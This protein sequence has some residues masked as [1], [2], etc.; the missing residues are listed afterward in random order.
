M[1][2]FKLFS[3]SMGMLLFFV[4]CSMEPYEGTEL[5][6]TNVK[7]AIDDEGCET[8]FAI[9]ASGISTCFLEDGFN[10]WGWTIGALSPSVNPRTYEIY[11][12]AGKCDISNPEVAGTVTLNYNGGS[13]TVI[14]TAALG[15]VFKETHVYIGT[16]EY[17]MQVKGNKTV[18]TV[19]PGQYPYKHDNLNNTD[20]D[21]YDEEEIGELPDG[22]IYFIAHAVVC[23]VATDTA[24][25]D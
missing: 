7:G 5:K 24:D 12:G 8:G 14:F 4:S 10:R 22:D 13:A 1:K 3:I 15:Y 23:K 17:P 21:T 25:V 9:C 6:A 19:A 2:N 16:T 18:P 11:A 20:I